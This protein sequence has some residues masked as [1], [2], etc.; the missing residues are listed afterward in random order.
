MITSYFKIAWRN[1]I[2]DRQFSLLNLMGLS[3]GLA[4]V[5]LI[6]LWVSDER[7]IDKFNEKD[8]QLFQVLK[9]GSNSDG[10]VVVRET[11]Q[12]LLAKNMAADIPEI[13]YAV[14]V[15][16]EGELGVLTSGEKH[17]K[18]SWEF[19]D[20][21][22]FNVF[23]YQLINGNKNNP[24]LDKYGV[25]LS[26]KLAMKLFNTTENII[27][28]TISWDAGSEFSGV[29]KIAGTFKAAPANASD[30]FDLL[31][32]YSLFVEKETD[33][34]GD[35]AFWG[36]NMSQTYL[37]L[38]KGTDVVA[39][40]NK[41]KDYTKT[42]IR[43][44]Y[45]NNDMDKYEGDLLVQRYSDKYL[46]NHF[47]NGVASGG[48][49]EYVKLFSAIA[50]FILIIA[51]INFMNL[52]TAKASRRIK[53]VGIRKVVG[54]QRGTLILQYLGESMMM[55]FLSLM[56]AGMMVIIFLPA[57]KE[58]TGKNLAIQFNAS[59]VFSFLSITLITGI[60]AGSYPA[61]YL[62]GFRPAL[63]LKG[64]LISSSG[65]SWVRKGL[66]VFQFSISVILIISV[67]VVYKQMDLV[68]TKNLGY[69]KDN[70]IHFASEGSLQKDQS[71]FLSE[72]KKIPGVINAS[73]MEG[74][75]VGNAGHS[76]GGISWEGKDPNLGIE[77]YG[78]GV[79]YNLM[80]TLSLSMKE[81]RMFS[82]N[83]GSDSSKVIFNE[84][85]INMMGIKNPVGKKVSLWGRENE[86]I[87]V[88]K[89]FHFESL[90]KKVGPLFFYYSPK[91][92]DLL[93]KIKAGKEKET[94]ASVEKFYKQFNSGLPFQFKFLDDDYQALYSSEQRV[95]LLSRYFAAVAIIISCLGLF[96]L[97]AFTAQKRQKEIGI[98]KI[99]GASAGNVVIM[100]SSDFLKLVLI[101]IVIAF[102]VSWL[103]MHKWLESFAY[104][105]P[106]SVGIF[107][108]A[109]FATV[110]ITLITISFQSIKAALMNPV[111][112]LRSE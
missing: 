86:I 41:I 102:P 93:V 15:R 14:S 57:F 25:L 88:V 110:F 68:R 55:A 46:Y 6:Y 97:A 67:M 89:D 82:A 108:I 63:V 40:N 24:L 91:N 76:G 39:F 85:A 99:V 77:Y 111:A 47:E 96:G 16:K 75:M 92:N 43:S 95:G 31:F 34:Q 100:L 45:K 7:S 35:V 29:Y 107:F 36:S 27:G 78:I 72:I 5:F 81:G 79:D 11:T 1:L 59:L 80:E 106:I 56:I 112:S 66:V 9:K 13:E 23:S 33:T 51:C 105:V 54:A 8:S 73:G 53:E 104:R 103:M 60:V 28:K 58:M 98:R 42:K 30:Q 10:T 90:Y 101:A 84:S 62:S 12:G 70:I 83:F 69:N 109:G 49:I 50:I 22:F 74:D 44:L 32:S 2:R 38:K 71:V 94:L 17:I 20:K 87:G 65:E 37:I 61:L 48:R 64:K 18:A 26:D 19:T 3:T 21:D 52:S 4:C